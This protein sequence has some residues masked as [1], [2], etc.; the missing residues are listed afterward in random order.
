MF[1]VIFIHTLSS[2]IIPVIIETSIWSIP[3]NL[4][5]LMR[6]S[7]ETNS[8]HIEAY[9]SHFHHFFVFVLDCQFSGKFV[10]EVNNV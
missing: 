7:N 9:D 2:N 10:V 5:R 8:K 1:A 4:I 6:A 3:W